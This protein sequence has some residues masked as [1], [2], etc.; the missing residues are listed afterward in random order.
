MKT[1][2]Q[3]ALSD[4][5]LFARSWSNNRPLLELIISEYSI[6]QTFSTNFQGVSCKFSHAYVQ[7][8][9]DAEHAAEH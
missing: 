2:H 3:K 1:S 4:V 6:K 9:S 7:K 8:K 5:F